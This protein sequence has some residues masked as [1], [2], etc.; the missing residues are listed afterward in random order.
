MAGIDFDPQQFVAPSDPAPQ[1][2]SRIVGLVIL[3]IALAG[4]GYVS[5]KLVSGTNPSSAST[6]SDNLQQIQQ[7][8]ADIKERID[9]L[10]TRHKVVASEP[11]VALPKTGPTVAPTQARSKPAYQISAASALDPQRIPKVVAPTPAPRPTA[12]SSESDAANREAWQATSNRLA[13]VAGVVG[14]QQGEISQTREQLNQLLAQTRRTALQFELTR[15]TERQSVGPLELQLKSADPKRQRYSLCVYVS[16][17]CVELKD[18]AL[19][20]VVVF[21]LSR[22]SMPLELVATRISHN[23]IVGYVEVPSESVHR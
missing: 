19:D 18:R 7:Q 5:Y 21:V 8:L 4:I 3:L 20:E 14:S 2:P 6:E 10:E 22:G 16:N 23:G 9:E 1:Q 11:A 12:A 17:E 13:D 15:G